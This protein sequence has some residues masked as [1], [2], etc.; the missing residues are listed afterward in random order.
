MRLLSVCLLF[1]SAACSRM[2]RVDHSIMSISQPLAPP[3]KGETCAP[4]CG[5]NFD[6]EW[7][8]W[9]EENCCAKGLVCDEG[10]STCQPSVEDKVDDSTSHHSHSVSNTSEV[11]DKVDDS[12]SHHS[13]SVSNTSEVEDKVDDSTSHHSH[14][15]SNTSEPQPL[16]QH[17]QKCAAS[18][19]QK[20]NGEW[21]DSV[22]G[23]KNCCAKGFGLI[24]DAKDR[25]CRADLGKKCH[26]TVRTP[27][28]E[29]RI[30]RTVRKLLR[31]PPPKDVWT[32]TRSCG[33][34]FKKHET[35]CSEETRRCCVASFDFIKMDDDTMKYMSQN[36][37]LTP[38]SPYTRGLGKRYAPPDGTSRYCCSG[39]AFQ[40]PDGD[41]ACVL[42]ESIHMA[43]V[44]RLKVL[45]RH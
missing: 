8:E 35:R 15:V 17:G 7:W 27:K 6:G 33:K 2:D 45:K 10:T 26:K 30:K 4:G 19:R 29:T 39:L 37:L 5:G 38:P 9:D 43:E 14:S 40:W 36:H 31:K 16:P 42:S 13:H 1:V 32:V 34:Y 21:W 44:M 23:E 18:C 24:C 22:G 11:E 3:G 20:S 41:Q 28:E 25:I 12:T